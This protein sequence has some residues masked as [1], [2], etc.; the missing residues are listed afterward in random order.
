MP[1]STLYEKIWID[2]DGF[3][4]ITVAIIPFQDKMNR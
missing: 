2:A 4:D 1:F 3:L